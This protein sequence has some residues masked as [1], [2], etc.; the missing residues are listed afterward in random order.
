MTEPHQ[1]SEIPV[2]TPIKVISWI[3]SAILGVAI[4]LALG[5]IL[6][7]SGVFLAISNYL[8]V[9]T[10]FAGAVVFLFAYYRYG[11]PD[12]LLYA[13]GAFGLWG[14]SNIVWYVN[15]LL[16]RRNEVFPG[17][18]DIGMIAAIFILTIAYQHAFPRKQV[19]GKILLAILQSHSSSRLRTSSPQGS[20]SRPG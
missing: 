17:L 10:A 13:A 12:C 15:T 3:F 8:Q 11:K 1:T 4:A 7:P 6:L 20:A 5:I 2:D 19:A 14:V 16:G 9:L 18:I